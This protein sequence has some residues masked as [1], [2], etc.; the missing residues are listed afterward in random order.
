MVGRS[1]GRSRR[2]G[3][4]MTGAAAAMLVF[5]AMA[6][7]TARQLPPPTIAEFA[8]QAV[9]HITDAPTN[10][11]GDSGTGAGDGGTGDGSA[12]TTTATTAPAGTSA[13]QPVVD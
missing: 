9:E 4:V 1:T 3:L 2:P 10:Q 8:P 12:G 11:A 6:T 7:L 13:D 5:F